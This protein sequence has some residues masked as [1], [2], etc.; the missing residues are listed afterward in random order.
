MQ[1]DPKN[2][3]APGPMVWRAV[4]PGFETNLAPKHSYSFLKTMASVHLPLEV[5][6]WKK[7]K[8]LVCLLL[9]FMIF[10]A[11]PI[12][13]ISADLFHFPRPW[14]SNQ[15]LKIDRNT[16]GPA[17]FQRSNGCWSWSQETDNISPYFIQCLV[18]SFT[19]KSV[20][21][22]TKNSCLEGFLPTKHT[23]HKH[24]HHDGALRLSSGMVSMVEHTPPPGAS[25]E[26]VGHGCRQRV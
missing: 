4:S 23:A 20:P 17:D 22:E 18:N 16:T 14:M 6:P 25:A 10:S 24:P 15:W 11:G 13:G 2:I 7:R 1:S 12:V 8:H 19:P 26:G 21:A 9:L 5:G 3:P